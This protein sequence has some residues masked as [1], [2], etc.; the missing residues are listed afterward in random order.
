MNQLFTLNDS[1][2]T[3]TAEIIFDIVGFP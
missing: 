1:A 2:P 3:T